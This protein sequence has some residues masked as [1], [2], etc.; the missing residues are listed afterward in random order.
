MRRLIY[1]LAALAALAPAAAFAY[2]GIPE[3][4]HGSVAATAG[5]PITALI[6]GATVAT[7]TV[8]AGG[9]YGYAPHLFLIPDPSG[10]RAGAAISFLVGDTLASQT[11]HF[12]NGAI[13]ELD[14]LVP[15]NANTSTTTDETATSTQDAATSTEQSV[16]PT[17]NAG[18][19]TTSGTSPAASSSATG[20][21]SP[22]LAPLMKNFLPACSRRYDLTGDHVV[23][24]DD[25]NYLLARWGLAGRGSAADIDCDGTVGLLDFNLLLAHWT[26]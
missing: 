7:T 20:A 9:T 25:F 18:T 1:S 22:L 11:A 5:T 13:V 17:S 6:G 24:L 12:S 3:S 8:E 19:T 15:A 2:P 23:N 10:T 26:I 4:F 16:T 14:L 21:D